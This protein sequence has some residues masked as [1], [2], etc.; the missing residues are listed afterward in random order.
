MNEI[1]GNNGQDYTIT[2]LYAL[3]DIVGLIVCAE[4]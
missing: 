1:G 3:L 2:D 4:K